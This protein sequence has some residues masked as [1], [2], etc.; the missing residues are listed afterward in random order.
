MPPRQRR[1][2]AALSIVGSLM[3]ALP[4]FEVLRYQNAEVQALASQRSGLDPMA[5]AVGVQR[6]LLQ[7]RDIAG[8]VLRGHAALEAERR[9][10]QADVDDRVA[11]LTMALAAG[12]WDR[13]A[14]ESDALREDWFALSG[15]VLARTVSAGDSDLA[16][17]LLVE[18][19][20]QVMDLLA[21]ASLP[22]IEPGDDTAVRAV[23][24]LRLVPR[25]A[26]GGADFLPVDAALKT[27]AD[28]LAR[29][30]ATASQRHA[31]LLGALAALALAVLALVAGLL[32]GPGTL[33]ASPLRRRTDGTGPERPAERDEADRL[34]QRLRTDG[35]AS[36]RPA[37][38]RASDPQPTRPTPL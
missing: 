18:Q 34:L 10:R 22:G 12:S 29:R 23:A 3:V 15:R 14:R 26:A 5:R 38:E 4:L 16:H 20:L 7:H 2:L 28:R 6:S 17:R 32:G 1:R 11:D 21:D 8:Q 36:Q 9:L 25:R 35:S 30:S 27:L 24:V 13:A 31:L 37:S 19:A 33:P